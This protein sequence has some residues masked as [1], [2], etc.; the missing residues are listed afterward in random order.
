MKIK[1]D[2][3]SG[4]VFIPK[5]TA[6]SQI[7]MSDTNNTEAL[8]TLYQVSVFVNKELEDRKLDTITSQMMY[9]YANAKKP[10]I[11]WIETEDGKRVTDT[12]ARRFVKKFV[13]NRINKVTTSSKVTR[14]EGL[15]IDE[16]AEA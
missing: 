4:A 2:P 7:I 8:Y 9:S 14:L 12:E 6:R 10:M 5:Q 15:E 11:A 3:K 1:T 16:P 13:E